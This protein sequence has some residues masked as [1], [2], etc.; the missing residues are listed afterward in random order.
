MCEILTMDAVPAEVW[1]GVYLKWIKA[2]IDGWDEDELWYGCDLCQ[3][4][5]YEYSSDYDACRDCPLKADNW[6]NGYPETSK[7]NIMYHDN[8]DDE[9]RVAIERFLVYVKPYCIEKVK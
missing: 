2:L 7:L 4:M 1:R 6:C 8:Q 5:E 9:W 3:W